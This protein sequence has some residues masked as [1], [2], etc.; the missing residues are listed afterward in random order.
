MSNNKEL[1]HNVRK[2][3]MSKILEDVMGIEEVGKY[4][5]IPKS[6]VYKLAQEGKIP[7]QKVGR[8]WRFLRMAVDEWLRDGQS[9]RTE[10]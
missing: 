2:E 6:T 9:N 3:L 1:Q 4:L 7:G 8:H 10:S 5:K